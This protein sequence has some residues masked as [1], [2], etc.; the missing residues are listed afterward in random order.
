MF[1]PFSS[2]IVSIVSI[3]DENIQRT[4]TIN[5]R[6]SGAIKIEIIKSIIGRTNLITPQTNL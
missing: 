4:D 5:R 3:T 6:T 2:G 1:L